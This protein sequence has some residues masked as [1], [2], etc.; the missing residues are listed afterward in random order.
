[1]STYYMLDTVLSALLI[2]IV[3]KQELANFLC[4]ETDNKHFRLC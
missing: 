2:C 4:K 1:M 3:L